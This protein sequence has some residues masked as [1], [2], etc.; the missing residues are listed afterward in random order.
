MKRHVLAILLAATAGS[1]RAQGMEF[2]T[3]QGALPGDAGFDNEQ[4]DASPRL[5]AA[6][7]AGIAIA[8]TFPGADGYRAH[9]APAIHLAY[10]P[11]FL[12]IGGLGINLYRASGWRFGVNVMPSRGRNESDDLHLR[13]LGDVD[14]TWRGGVFG[15]YYHEG[16]LARASLSTD[17]AGHHQGTIA[18]FDIY[19]RRPFGEGLVL[20]GGPGITWSDRTYTQSFFGVTPDQSAR[21]G[22]PEF[23]AGAG[24][25]SARL[26]AGAIYRLAPRWR[27]LSSYSYARLTGDAGSSPITESRNQHFLGISAVYLVR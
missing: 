19:A 1:A 24:I 2:F 6:V 25:S 9:L 27:L 4:Q 11:V 15:V 16:Y 3:P 12:G 5:R 21:S 8:P 20:F 22:L 14:R 23:D 10:G 18:R 13:G 17:I 7:G 26:S